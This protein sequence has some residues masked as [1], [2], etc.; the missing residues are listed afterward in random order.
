MAIDEVL[1]AAP[2]TFTPADA[3]A[4]ARDLFGVDGTAVATDSERDQT[5]LL[6][7]ARPAVLKI[8]NAAEDPSRLDMEALAAQRVAQIDPGVPVALPWRVPGR[9]GPRDDP[10]AYRVPTRGADG[11][12]HH[13]RMY[14]RLPGRSWVRGADLPD[15]A[16]RDWGTMAARVGRALRGF[17]HPAA[18]RVMLWDA[19]HALRLRPLLAAVRDDEVR[20]LVA[21]A[22]DRYERAV[23]PVWPSLRSQVIH[24]DLCG[25]NVLVDTDGRV[26]GIVDFGDASW[27]A[28]VV[29]PVAVL[30]TIVEG[31]EGDD[32][33]RSARIALDGYDKVSPLEP[34]ERAILGELLAARMCAAVVVPASRGA[35]YDDPDA[36]QPSVRDLGT[37]V[38]RTI[39]S[40]GWDEVARQLGGREPGTGWSVPA[41]V[42][43]RRQVVGPAM[44]APTYR[45]PLHLVRGE[46][47]WLIDAEGQR[48]LDAYNNV[49]VVGHE[50]PRVVEAIVRQ[51]RRLNTN[52]RYLHETA[53]EVAER[54]IASTGGELDV[55]MFVNSGSEA[56]DIAWRIARAA[57][58]GTGGITTDFAYHGITDAVTALTPEEWGTRPQ[59]AHVRTWRPPDTLR[60]FDGPLADFEEAIVTLSQAGHRP[61]AAIL[62][63]VLTSDGIIGLEPSTA[64]ELVRR[65]HEA[66]ALWIADEVQGG[67]GRTGAA[68][69][70]YQRLG[71]TPDIVTLGKPMGNGHPVAALLTRRELAERL[72][73]DGEFFST[74]GGNPVAMA[75]AL[76]VLEVID[77]EHVIENARGVGEYLAGRLRVVTASVPVVGEVRSVGLAIGVEIVRPATNEP[78][79]PK[80]REILE[81]MRARHVLIGT[82]GR[83]GNT[84]KIRPPLV[85]Q[86]RDADLLVATLEAVL[87]T[88]R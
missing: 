20:E 86:H 67:H 39:E 71:I 1:T 3:A 83:A 10:A 66:G 40:I 62:D 73:P 7:A 46:G 63:A 70:S 47:V 43:R 22:L 72:S 69:W 32:L 77:D 78:D 44:T 51:A 64:R 34:G 59:P 15:D 16:V 18:A 55:V 36:L 54:L 79:A 49:P 52:M 88:A 74:F 14:D 76:A 11:A 29:D 25:S 84:L 68:M 60:G 56:N 13:V 82:T 31:R 5:F 26:T 53:L 2:P 12:L 41:L 65:T 48:Y 8:S 37:A 33:F 61:A 80:A 6:D 57:T 85:V 75:A 28:L 24:T 4:L 38:L 21:R 9:A 30:E 27:S 81:E 45:E 42:E 23:A 19:Q 50:H 58:G 87:A 17:W 35:L